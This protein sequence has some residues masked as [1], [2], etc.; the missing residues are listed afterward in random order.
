MEIKV[1]SQYNKWFKS[2]KD[3]TA[4]AK[5]QVRFDRILLGNLGDYRSVGGGVCELRIDFGPGYRIFFG[6]K[7]GNEIIIIT[8]GSTKKN[9]QQVIEQAKQLWKKIKSKK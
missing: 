9:Q 3:N 6:Q 5:I 4:K 7:R 2:L 8:A 1:T